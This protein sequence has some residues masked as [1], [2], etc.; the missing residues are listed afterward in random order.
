[1]CKN[2][3]VCDQGVNIY[4]LNK[5]SWA[6][7]Y[8]VDPSKDIV[9]FSGSISAPDPIVNPRDRLEPGGNKGIRLLIDATQPIG[10]PRAEEYFGQKFAIIAYP[11][12][13]TIKKVRENW[14]KCG[15]QRKGAVEE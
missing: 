14:E 4:D 15:I 7:G 10:R 3:I 13:E 11:D 2:I 6:I 5:V 8:R 9:Q 1:M 12:Q